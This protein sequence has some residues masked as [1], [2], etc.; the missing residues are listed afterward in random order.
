MHFKMEIFNSVFRRCAWQWPPLEFTRKGTLPR[1]SSADPPPGGQAAPSPAGLP[2]GLALL[3]ASAQKPCSPTCS[4]LSR[5]PLTFPWFSSP[6]EP[7]PS[8]TDW[9]VSRRPP[10]CVSVPAWP[11]MTPANAHSDSLNNLSTSWCPGARGRSGAASQAPR[12]RAPADRTPPSPPVLC[13]TAPLPPAS[14]PSPLRI[15]PS[16]DAQARFFLLLCWLL[17]CGFHTLDFS[18]FLDGGVPQGP[19]DSSPLCP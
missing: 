11:R 1:W 4:G 6:R 9:P 14:P 5:K 8:V 16:G 7:V 15:R 12:P 19:S 10:S 18:R 17:L 13:Q 2:G 3:A